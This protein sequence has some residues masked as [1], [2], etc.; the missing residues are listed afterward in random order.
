MIVRDEDV[1]LL[2][3]ALQKLAPPHELEQRIV[4][5]LDGRA[6]AKPQ[7]ALAIAAALGLAAGVVATIMLRPERA[8]SETPDPPS[9]AAVAPTPDPEGGGEPVDDGL[10]FDDACTYTRAGL[11]LRLAERCRVRIDEPAV[12][13]DVWSA[14]K[15]TVT[16]RGVALVSGTVLFH[17]AEV[18][19]ADAPVRVDVEGGAIEVVGTRFVVEA[20]PEGGRLDLLEGNVRFHTDDEIIEVEPGRRHAWGNFVATAPPTPREPAKSP[21]GSPAGSPAGPEAS[22]DLVEGLA[23]VAR[24]RQRGE[25]T[26]AVQRLRA[27][28][29]GV[30][31]RHAREV[32]SFEEG[33]LLEKFESQAIA[34]SHWAR[35]ARRF[36]AGSYDAEVAR[37][38]AA[39]GCE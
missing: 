23:E 16:P 15:L 35:H 25:H 26:A 10:A 5:E 31:D 7:R 4:R 19:D 13:L 39:L 8:P 27:L 34:C 17:V 32:L 11:D 29:R 22:V 38:R 14:A 21:S 28:G 6:T 18:A 24:L 33:T 2:D 3:G 20:T 30:R 1:R 36:G 9:V 12:E 37:R